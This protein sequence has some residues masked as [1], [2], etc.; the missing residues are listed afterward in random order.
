QRLRLPEVPDPGDAALV[1]Q[2]V[3]DLARRGLRA[4][5]LDHPVE[6]GRL[7]EDVRPEQ[8]DAPLVA[9]ELEHRPVPEHT[10]VRV[11]A[12]HEP[13]LPDASGAARLDAPAAA[14][15]QMAVELEPAVEAQQEILP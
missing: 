3:A 9:P 2:G 10:L 7:G 12:Q 8:P 13:R 6:V 1:E 11:A 15:P 14:H 5:P 4:Q